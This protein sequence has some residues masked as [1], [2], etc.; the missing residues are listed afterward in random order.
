MR[1]KKREDPCPLRQVLASLAE[2]LGEGCQ[3]RCSCRKCCRQLLA[4]QY[5]HTHTCVVSGT[6]GYQGHKDYTSLKVLAQI[7]DHQLDPA[8]PIFHLSALLLFGSQ[9]GLI[10]NV[11]VCM[12]TNTHEALCASQPLH[13]I[14]YFRMQGTYSVHIHTCT[15]AAITS[16]SLSLSAAMQS[17]TIHVQLD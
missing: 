7:E 8:S 16:C 3:I 13:P 14:V 5:T 1:R 12:Y 4:S 17:T 11:H 6:T 15:I 10:K 9:Q 2:V